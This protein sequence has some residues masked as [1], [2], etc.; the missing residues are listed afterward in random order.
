MTVYWRAK[1]EKRFGSPNEIRTYNPVV[2]S[3]RVK[4]KK[5]KARDSG[6]KS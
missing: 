1:F 3:E 5:T 2:N 6:W 4:F